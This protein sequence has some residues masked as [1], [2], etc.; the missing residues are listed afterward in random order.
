MAGM[1]LRKREGIALVVALT[2]GFVW[3]ICGYTVDATPQKAGIF[4]GLLLVLLVLAG[5]ISAFARWRFDRWRAL[6][7]LGIAFGGLALSWAA[8]VAGFE[9]RN[10]EFV[11]QRAPFEQFARAFQ[12]G[13]VRPG[14]F[15]VDSLPPA[16]RNCCYLVQG[17]RDSTGVWQVEFLWGRSLGAARSAW[18][19]SSGGAVSARGQWH[20]VKELA[21]HWYRMTD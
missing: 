2:A 11:R 9:Y 14:K 16:L 8:L 19:F 15:P 21:P 3:G 18:V 20:Q 13:A 5:I 1:R 7:M 4:L 6:S 17:D 10:R 12:S